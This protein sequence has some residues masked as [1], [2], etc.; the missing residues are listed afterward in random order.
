M[1]NKTKNDITALIIVTMVIIIGFFLIFWFYSIVSTLGVQSEDISKTLEIKDA[2]VEQITSQ[3]A[4]NTPLLLE[5][6]D[7]GRENPF[8]KIN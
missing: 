4:Q 1:A 5:G 8:G 7:F 3:N 2:I 6:N